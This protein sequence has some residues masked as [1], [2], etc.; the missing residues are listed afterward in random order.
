MKTSASAGGPRIELRQQYK[1]QSYDNA[2]WLFGEKPQSVRAKLHVVRL[3]D[4]Q[5]TALAGEITIMQLHGV[6]RGTLFVPAI[7]M[8]YGTHHVDGHRT[9]KLR[10]LNPTTGNSS[11]YEFNRH[12]GYYFHRTFELQMITGADA[13]IEFSGV[14]SYGR[15]FRAYASPETTGGFRNL[16]SYYKVGNYPQIQENSSLY[17]YSVVI[18][19]NVTVGE[20]T[21][22]PRLRGDDGRSM[23]YMAA[24]VVSVAVFLASLMIFLFWLVGSRKKESPLE[25]GSLL[26]LYPR[27]SLA[28]LMSL[29]VFELVASTALAFVPPLVREVLAPVRSYSW[30]LFRS[31]V[32]D[33]WGM[34]VLPG[35][36][37]FKV[38]H[39]LCGRFNTLKEVGYPELVAVNGVCFAIALG[40]LI[41]ILVGHSAP[42]LMNAGKNRVFVPLDSQTHLA[43][44]AAFWVQAG[45]QLLL[46]FPLQVGSGFIALAALKA[47]ILCRHLPGGGKKGA[48]RLHQ[49]H[50]VHVSWRHSNSVI[51]TV[52]LE[53]RKRRRWLTGAEATDDDTDQLGHFAK[54]GSDAEHQ[55]T[56]ID[57][58]I[59]IPAETQAGWAH[60]RFLVEGVNGA[61]CR[62][63]VY[64]AILGVFVWLFYLTWVNAAWPVVYAREQVYFYGIPLYLICVFASVS[65]SNLC[66]VS[67]ALAP[68]PP[69]N[70]S[71]PS[72][73]ATSPTALPPP[74]A[75][76]PDASPPDASPPDA[77]PSDAPPSDAPP[78]D[79]PPPDAPPPDAPPPDAP[80]SDAP[81]SDTSPPDAP[82]RDAP[83]P[84]AAPPDASPPAP[85]S[86]VPASPPTP[87]SEVATVAAVTEVSTAVM[88][89]EVAVTAEPPWRNDP[90]F[91]RK[92]GV[93]IPCHKSA[94]EIA[95][96]LRPL[97]LYF[98]PSH[99]VVCDNGNALTPGDH[100]NN[101]TASEVRQVYEDYLK[102]LPDDLRQTKA[103]IQYL[104]IPEGQKMQALTLGSIRLSQTCHNVEYVMHIDDDTILSDAMV[105][106]ESLFT[107]NPNL[108]AVAFPRTVDCSAGSTLVS[109]SVD[110]FYK[111]AD[112]MGW[113]Q[114]CLS[115]T[116]PYVPGP[117]GLWKLSVYHKMIERHPFLPFGED[118]FGSYVA[119]CLD[120]RRYCFTSEMRCKVQTFGPPSLTQ[121]SCSCIYGTGKKERVQGYGSASLWKQRAHR[122]CVSGCRVLPY[123]VFCFFFYRG[124]YDGGTPT[125]TG[126]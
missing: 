2:S 7:V 102:G 35:L 50:S 112:H 66:F 119:L 6:G 29:Y 83:P 125:C 85:L 11:V 106:D 47:R 84:D 109:R 99:I 87:P 48:S 103:P 78:R 22:F 88:A 23:W 40:F 118:I 38:V 91:L 58:V 4:T 72:S 16:S 93:A 100:D 27:T 53:L 81:P 97:L 32:N 43:T 111:K 79:A 42:S 117:C 19:E 89:A 9:L 3:P 122:W 98:E 41:I 62:V 73:T 1:P 65:I 67:L 52:E 121:C 90:A 14:D 25:G 12:Q 51:P 92:I 71:P 10:V 59:A 8:L 20:D 5:R 13:S 63:L 17:D 34:F 28:L 69:L 64:Y 94:D 61:A 70:P 75:P 104:F 37:F 126:A 44:Y 56:P 113:A 101:A 76:P 68:L 82:P 86:T 18:L 110:F 107:R 116:R 124:S 55:A 36:S 24:L 49:A 26:M 96:T 31:F 77:P 45:V 105:F 60:T 74:N 80:P 123:S 15:P 54:I 21:T 46:F 114:A 115:G 57:A 95:R 39:G 120:E 108:V 30:A 33:S